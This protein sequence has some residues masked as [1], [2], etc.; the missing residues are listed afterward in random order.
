MVSIF[1]G[2]G[3][4]SDSGNLYSDHFLASPILLT[5]SSDVIGSEMFHWW[6]GGSDCHPNACKNDTFI[7]DGDRDNQW[8]QRTVV[9][10]TEHCKR[11]VRICVFI[12]RRIESHWVL[13]W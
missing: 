4:W 1:S 10:Y 3:T 13:Y 2:V 6:R 9:L 5:A 7:T 8:Y 12:W 11:A